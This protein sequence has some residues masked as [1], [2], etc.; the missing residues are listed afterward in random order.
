MKDTSDTIKLSSLEAAVLR[1]LRKMDLRA[2]DEMLGMSTI[3]AKSYPSAPP[4]P[5]LHLVKSTS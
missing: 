3:W 2:R 1:N 4:R 5:L